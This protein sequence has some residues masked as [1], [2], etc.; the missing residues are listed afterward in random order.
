M[1]NPFLIGATVYLRPLETED[2]PTLVPWLNDPEVSRFLARYRPVTLAEE[3]D[4]LRHINDSPTD[5]VLGIALRAEDRLV[6]AIGLHQM[7]IRSRNAKFGIFIGDRNWWG[8]GC[9][10]EATRL[11]V[12]HA[13]ET[14]N[15]HRVSLHVY[16]Y[17]ERA[18]KVY[19]KVGFRIEGRLRQDTFREGQYWDTI[20]MAVLREEWEAVDYGVN[21]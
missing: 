18:L 17:N 7:D 10:T 5:L 6:G 8:K 11:I 12:R 4:F 16:E 3:V 1:R 20:V 19:Q 21:V 9:G 13:F 15:L 14:L 2:A